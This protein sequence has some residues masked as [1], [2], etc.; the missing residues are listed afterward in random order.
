MGLSVDGLSECA[1]NLKHF[2]DSLL[3]TYKGHLMLYTLV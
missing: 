3:S 1:R 2:H